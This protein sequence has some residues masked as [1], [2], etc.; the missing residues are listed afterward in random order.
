M[1][2][3]KIRVVKI[4][5]LK[6]STYY[7]FNSKTRLNKKKI[8]TKK[9]SAGEKWGTNC[10]VLRKC[11]RK[12][13][14]NEEENEMLGENE[15]K[16]V[17]NDT[18]NLEFFKPIDKICVYNNVDEEIGKSRMKRVNGVPESILSNLRKRSRTVFSRNNVHCV[19]G[20]IFQHREGIE[21]R[22]GLKSING[23]SLQLGN[24]LSAHLPFEQEDPHYLNSSLSFLE[25]RRN[26][27]FQRAHLDY[28]WNHLCDRAPEDLPWI[29]VFPITEEGMRLHVWPYPGVGKVL[30][31]SIGELVFLRGDLVHAGGIGKPATRCHFYLP[32][33]SSDYD[34][35]QGTNWR[36]PNGT[37]LCHSHFLPVASFYSW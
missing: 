6:R 36:D 11:R 16:R 10:R 28:F 23:L 26:Q 19:N 15:S 20:N 2:L 7:K 21:W 35:Q 13:K 5:V 17:R 32:K 31:I 22:F 18:W 3:S 8:E 1:D 14:M 33:F 12:R 9:P 24:F 25:T 30:N 37:M 29:C 27:T 4:T 34:E